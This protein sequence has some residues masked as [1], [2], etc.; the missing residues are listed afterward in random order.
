MTARAAGARIR[1]S[2]GAGDFH[3][4]CGA[5]WV[6]VPRSARRCGLC[7]AT[8]RGPAVA[9]REPSGAV[10]WVSISPAVLGGAT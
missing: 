3:W 10:R 4:P 8:E 7:G 1:W 2:I 9:V 5:T 6:R